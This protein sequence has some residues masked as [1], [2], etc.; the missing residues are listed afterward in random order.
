MI[1]PKQQEMKK[2]EPVNSPHMN[3]FRSVRLHLHLE[4]G[5]KKKQDR[6]KWQTQMKSASLHLH[7]AQ[8][9]SKQPC[10][11]M[12]HLHRYRA[13]SQTAGGRTRVE[14]LHRRVRC[15]SIS[16][17]GCRSDAG[18]RAFISF[19]DVELCPPFLRCLLRL[20]FLPHYS[21]VIKL[22]ARCLLLPII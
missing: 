3:L 1:G 22:S 4:I 19:S 20:G 10:H 15:S 12:R 2:P 13:N 5:P 7:L 17:W 14:S 16:R 21:A 9:F 8:T 18:R 11:W 6:M